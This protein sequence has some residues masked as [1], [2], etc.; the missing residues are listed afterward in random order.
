MQPHAINHHQTISQISFQKDLA[1]P[2]Q[3]STLKDTYGSEIE[4]FSEASV[5]KSY[6]KGS[7]KTAK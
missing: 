5:M 7:E 3:R 4:L 1:Y 6:L 2:Q